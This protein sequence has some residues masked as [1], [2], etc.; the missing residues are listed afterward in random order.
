MAIELQVTRS[1]SPV[2][3]ETAT[4][5]LVEI[6]HCSAASTANTLTL[7]NKIVFEIGTHLTCKTLSMLIKHFTTYE[8]EVVQLVTMIFLALS[9]TS[10]LIIDLLLTVKEKE[11]VFEHL[12][13][14]FLG[15]CFVL[16]TLFHS[17]DIVIVL[18]KLQ[19]S[20]LLFIDQVLAHLSQ[21]IF[22]QL[23]VG[24]LIDCNSLTE[25]NELCVWITASYKLVFIRGETL[26]SSIHWTVHR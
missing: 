25:S 11:F 16:V 26:T 15:V 13:C 18:L 12:V 5:C 10:I 8:R 9:F 14:T 1:H 19:I 17:S 7:C 6:V 21:M 22:Q 23:F 4:C 24:H 20:F 3:S 2:A